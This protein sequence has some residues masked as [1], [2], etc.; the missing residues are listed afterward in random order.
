M[1]QPFFYYFSGGN[2]GGSQNEKSSSSCPKK[3]GETEEAGNGTEADIVVPSEDLL[4]PFGEVL[5]KQE[6][7][8]FEYFDLSE[9][10]E[11]DV[12]VL[13]D[14]DEDFEDEEDIELS[15]GEG[16]EKSEDSIPDVSPV[17]VVSSKDEDKVIFFP[18]LYPSNKFVLMTYST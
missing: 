5:V 8:D 17:K 10:N 14:E 13:E 2:T 3:R 11:D 18:S 4:L 6:A 16:E 7:E 9:G 12:I 1:C 15:S